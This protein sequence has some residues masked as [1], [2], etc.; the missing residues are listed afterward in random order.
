MPTELK[1]ILMNNN[2]VRDPSSGQR[3]GGAPYAATRSAAQLHDDD[4]VLS[5]KS[6]PGQLGGVV[7][8]N[9]SQ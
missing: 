4:E 3:Y 5:A 7:L 1:G 9:L 2:Y 8:S 6:G